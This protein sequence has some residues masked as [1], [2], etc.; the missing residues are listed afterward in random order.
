MIIW[1]GHADETGTL[2]P[3][4]CMNWRKVVNRIVFLL[5]MHIF[6]RW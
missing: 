6:E 3:E 5:C 1:G 4:P 2:G